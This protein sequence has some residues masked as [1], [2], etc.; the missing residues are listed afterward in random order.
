MLKW[1]INLTRYILL[2]LSFS[3]L[4]NCSLQS[5]LLNISRLTVHF[6]VASAPCLRKTTAK[7]WS[8][9]IKSRVSVSEKVSIN[10]TPFLNGCSFNHCCSYSRLIVTFLTL[11]VCAWSMTTMKW[12]Q[13]SVMLGCAHRYFMSVHSKPSKLASSLSISNPSLASFILR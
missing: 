7:L 6:W 3:I 10:L 8:S 1:T 9:V 2:S 5:C 11:T 12:F 13:S 4:I